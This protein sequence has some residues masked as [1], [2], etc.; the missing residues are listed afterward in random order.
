MEAC[1]VLSGSGKCGVILLDGGAGPN[2]R[3]KAEDLC[4]R[5]DTELRILPAGMIERTTGRSNIVI[6]VYKGSFADTICEI[7]QYEMP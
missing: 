3:K 7:T 5:T 6:A 1:R 2:T 4:R